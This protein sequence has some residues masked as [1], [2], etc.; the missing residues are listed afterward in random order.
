VPGFLNKPGVPELNSA[1][2]QEF[3]GLRRKLEPV[4]LRPVVRGNETMMLLSADANAGE[5]IL[6]DIVVRRK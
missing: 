2:W 1:D 6:F 3:L 4:Q 5:P